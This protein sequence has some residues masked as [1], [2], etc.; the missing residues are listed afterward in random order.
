MNEI[1]A[2]R[3]EHGEPERR[4]FTKYVARSTTFFGK[5]LEFMEKRDQLQSR[6][7]E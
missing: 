3:L 7:A 6:I 5:M 4:K 2:R 1:E